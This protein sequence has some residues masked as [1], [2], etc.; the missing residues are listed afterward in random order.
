MGHPG[1]KLQIAAA[2]AKAAVQDKW[3]WIPAF[4]GMTDGKLAPFF[5]NFLAS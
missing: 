1:S 4:A 3:P 2:F 5:R